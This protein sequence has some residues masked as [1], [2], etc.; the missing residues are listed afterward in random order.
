MTSIV[1]LSVELTILSAIAARMY[2][3]RLGGSSAS[4]APGPASSPRAISPPGSIRC[5]RSKSATAD[6]SDPSA[7]I[8]SSCGKPI[9]PTTDGAASTGRTRSSAYGFDDG[10]HGAGCNPAARRLWMSPPVMTA[11]ADARDAPTPT[12]PATC[13]GACGAGAG[14]TCGVLGEP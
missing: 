5:Q 8:G 6:A 14:A 10:G 1:I 13:G 9:A 12:A 7:I 4:S 2:G 11:G 3:M